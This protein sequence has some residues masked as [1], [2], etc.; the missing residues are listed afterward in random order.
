MVRHRARMGR[1]EANMVIKRIGGIE[2][3]KDNI[4]VVYKCK[5]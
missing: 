1:L 5:G 3:G 2:G 4:G